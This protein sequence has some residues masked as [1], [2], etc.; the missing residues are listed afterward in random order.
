MKAF[1]IAVVFVL[2]ATHAAHPINEPMFLFV[3]ATGDNANSC[4]AGTSPCL[5]IQG[6]VDKVPF[7]TRGIINVAA[8]TY[9]DPVN[10]VGYLRNFIGI[11]GPYNEVGQCADPNQV[12]INTP[13]QV[14]FWGQ[15][16]ATLIVSCLKIGQAST[17]I[18]GRQGGTII[19]FASIVFGNVT[20]GVAATDMAIASC[21]SQVWLTANMSA[22][23]FAARGHLNMG[24]QFN[25]AAGLT[26]SSFYVGKSYSTID[27]SGSSYE[28]AGGSITG[29]KW[30]LD[31]SEI[32]PNC[33]VPGTGVTQL[34]NAVAPVGC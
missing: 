19:D 9:S 18:A 22:F 27:T 7:G 3:A 10:V 31:N 25:I 15:D 13:G 24:C 30:H 32:G 17:G 6:A 8:G 29:E 4:T 1:V 11:Y 34:R 12:V 14:A 2:A 21:G 28:I 33:N 20:T 23:G 26:V 16:H 5:T